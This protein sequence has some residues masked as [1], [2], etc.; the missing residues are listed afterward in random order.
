MPLL[1]QYRYVYG[2]VPST[3]RPE[4]GTSR[5]RLRPEY[6][7]FSCEAWISDHHPWNDAQGRR[8][9]PSPRRHRDARTE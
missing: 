9:L 2:Y 4:Y 3:A 1:P 8:R 6:G 5:V 7:Y